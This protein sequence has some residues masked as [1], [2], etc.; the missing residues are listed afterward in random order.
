MVKRSGEVYMQFATVRVFIM[1]IIAYFEVKMFK[2]LTIYLFISNMH[3]TSLITS[4]IGDISSNFCESRCFY[5]FSRNIK[6][7]S[8]LKYARFKYK[9]NEMCII[10]VTSLKLF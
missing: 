4:I 7:I 1:L 8:L 2:F 6:S 9:I 10:V 5:T 3:S